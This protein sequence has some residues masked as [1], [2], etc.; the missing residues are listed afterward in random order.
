[1]LAAAVAGDEEALHAGAQRVGPLPHRLPVGKELAL[2]PTL[3]AAAAAAAR[4]WLA[5]STGGHLV[6]WVF[7]G[8]GEV[9]VGFW[10]FV[11]IPAA[12]WKGQLMKVWPLGKGDWGLGS[13]EAIDHH[14][15]IIC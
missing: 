7:V 6:V 8:G 10:G 3:G 4:A 11:G 15:Q 1:V 13:G 5:L 2:P 12:P 14:R 9:A